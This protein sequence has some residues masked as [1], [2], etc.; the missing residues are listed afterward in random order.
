MNPSCP[1]CD[2]LLVLETHSYTTYQPSKQNESR[3]DFY[4]CYPCKRH[5]PRQA[6]IMKVTA[7]E[8]IEPRKVRK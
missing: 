1:F 6:A 8:G 2:H 5:W 3:A 7:R 4:T